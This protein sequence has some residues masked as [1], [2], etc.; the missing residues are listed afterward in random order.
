[1]VSAPFIF[2]FGPFKLKIEYCALSHR[3]AFP[4]LQPRGLGAAVYA[5]NR[6]SRRD[7]QWSAEIALTWTKINRLQIQGNAVAVADNGIFGTYLNPLRPANTADKPAL[8]IP[9]RPTS[10]RSDRV[11]QTLN[12]FIHHH[13][14]LPFISSTTSHYGIAS[15]DSF[16]RWSEW[17]TI[18]HVLLPRTPEAPRL[19]ELS[20]TPDKTRTSGNTVSH[21]LSLEIVWDWQDRSPKRFQLAGIFH[22]R[23]YFPDGTKDNGHIPPTSYPMI[24][25]TD[26]T[27]T[28]GA[29]VELT[30]A[31]DVPPGAPPVFTAVPTSPNPDVTVELLPQA[32]NSIGENVEGEM[33]RYRVKMRN[34][35]LTFQP[36]E[37]WYF[38]LFVKA[39]EWRNPLLPE[40]YFCSTPA[41]PPSSSYSI[42][43][44]SY[45]CVATGFHPCNYSLDVFA[46]RP[47][48]ITIPAGVQSSAQRHRRICCF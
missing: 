26:N 18:D 25:Q 38:T 27:A 37:E 6:P 1:M 15:M 8:F 5:Q 3:S 23:Q 35:T 4:T 10:A 17:S 20:L 2:K 45:S 19:N 47:R 42:R 41:R 16:G 14:K 31:S 44:Q 43:S 12:R 7:D 34:L 9:M 48:H 22:R 36:N 24:L 13:A 28:V 40:R 32:T 46:R 39:A 21:E 11:L 29:L 33:R 30:F